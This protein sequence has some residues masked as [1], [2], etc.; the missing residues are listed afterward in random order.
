M[1]LMKSWLKSSH[2]KEG[3]RFLGSGHMFMRAQLC[4]ALLRPP[5]IVAHQAPLSRRFPK[6]E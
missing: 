4:P 3:N 5:C 6:Q 1:Y 2:P